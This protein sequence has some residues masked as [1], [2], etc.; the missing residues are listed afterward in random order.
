MIPD[1]DIAN[2]RGSDIVTDDEVVVLNVA[3][4][5]KKVPR[6]VS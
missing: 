5:L 1:S 6:Q 4:E 2:I 3:R